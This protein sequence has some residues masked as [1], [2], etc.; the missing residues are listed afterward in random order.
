MARVFG[1]R[2]IGAIL[3]SPARPRHGRG[4]SRLSVSPDLDVVRRRCERG[5]MIYLGRMVEPGPAAQVFSHTRHACTRARVIPKGGE[6]TTASGRIR[7]ASAQRDPLKPAPA[8][9][10][11][12]GPGRGERARPAGEM[13]LPRDFGGGTRAACDFT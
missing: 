11:F 12:D 10:R 1:M 2:L 7:L 9:G 13:P 4:P 5:T 8:A 6:G 3:P